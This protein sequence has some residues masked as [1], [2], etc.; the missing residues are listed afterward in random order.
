MIGRGLNTHHDSRFNMSKNGNGAASGE[1]PR[2]SRPRARILGQCI[3]DMSFE[4]FLVQGGSRVPGP[5]EFQV[6]INL[7]GKKLNDDE[8][9]VVVKLNLESREKDG[10]KQVYLLELEYSGFFKVENA[11]A[12]ALQQFLMI[13]CPRLMF[14]FLRRIVSDITKDGGFPSFELELIDFARLYQNE[15][16][17]R[18]VSTASTDSSEGK[19]GESND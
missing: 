10:S 2:V 11:P 9:E 7:D 14:P 8:Y 13:E 17:R 12:G 5:L 19:K 18:A 1:V 16:N 6:Q 15:M 4:N 3:R